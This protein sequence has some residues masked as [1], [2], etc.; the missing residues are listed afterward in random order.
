[1]PEITL[2]D[3][4]QFV[5]RRY[6][7]GVYD[8][9][10]MAAEVQSVL[11]GRSVRIPG[12]YYRGRRGQAAALERHVDTASERI[13]APETGC[14]VLMWESV[15]GFDPADP[16]NRRWHLGTVFLHDGLVWV[17]HNPNETHGAMLQLES[18]LRRHGLHVEEYRRWLG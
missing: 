16:M 1:M 2:R 10:D 11:F 8:C 17:L 6:V 4:E 15:A 9:A 13:D 18:E 3:A 5:G 7:A 12:Q 14:A